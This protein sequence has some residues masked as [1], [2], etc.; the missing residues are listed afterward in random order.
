MAVPAAPPA[1]VRAR[2]KKMGPAVGRRRG[3][4]PIAVN[5][6][7]KTSPATLPVTGLAR[8]QPAHALRAT[9]VQDRACSVVPA[10]KGRIGRGSRRAKSVRGWRGT[11]AGVAAHCGLRQ[12]R[13]WRAPN[14]GSYVGRPRCL[15]GSCFLVLP[16]ARRCSTASRWAPLA[17]SRDG[18]GGSAGQAEPV[19]GCGR[20]DLSIEP[21]RV[22]KR[23]G[24]P[25][26]I[27]TYR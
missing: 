23:P 25:F 18:G 19:G 22:C 24:K 21:A 14:V 1:V 2:Y 17:G 27:N 5:R 6:G 12:L 10:D 7:R 11:L 16:L 13:S 4:S 3:P 8:R 20:I 15:R 9:W 26:R